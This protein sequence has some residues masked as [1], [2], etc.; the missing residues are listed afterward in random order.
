MLLNSANSVKAF[1]ENSNVPQ[2]HSKQR[3]S[4][5]W[6]QFMLQWFLRFSEFTDFSESFAPFR[7]N[8]IVIALF[9]ANIQF[10][11]RCTYSGQKKRDGSTSQ[12]RDGD[13]WILIKVW[14]IPGCLDPKN[15]KLILVDGWKWLFRAFQTLLSHEICGCWHNK[16]FKINFVVI[17]FF[18]QVS[19]KSSWAKREISVAV[20]V[21]NGGTGS[22]SV[23]TLTWKVD[24]ETAYGLYQN[25]F[26]KCSTFYSKNL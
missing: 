8:P 10:C 21:Q 23:L 14:L 1:R 3:R 13:K 22:C 19:V 17:T 11:K 26:K 12:W 15:N 7:E 9:I 24:W 4:L 20:T 25:L 6:T 18:P 2:R 5:N 16:L